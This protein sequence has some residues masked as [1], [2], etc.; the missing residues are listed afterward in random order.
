MFSDDL[1]EIHCAKYFA[2]VYL[3]ASVVSSNIE[4]L[5]EEF[6][7]EDEEETKTNAILLNVLDNCEKFFAELLYE[8]EVFQTYLDSFKNVRIDYFK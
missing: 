8:Q 5:E 2:G 3:L 6:D 7:D 4:E 1:Q